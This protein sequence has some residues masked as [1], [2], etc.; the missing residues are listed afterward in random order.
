MKV[1]VITEDPTHDQHIVK[2][3]V[4]RIFRDRGR[5]PRL[6]FA[7]K[8]GCRGWQQVLA[9]EAIA[10]FISRFRDAEF[11]I[12]I[13]DRDCDC[14]RETGIVAQRLR[15]A[16]AAGR[17]IVACIAVEELE[18]WALALH[19][20]RS[21]EWTVDWSVVRAECDSKRVFFERFV[22]RRNWHLGVG[23]GRKAAMANLPDRW[24]QLKSR[25]TEIDRLAVE[26]TPRTED[27]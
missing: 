22:R 23:K 24:S 19:H 12:L 9:R 16:R 21:D 4:E 18:T 3:V 6:Y 13:V 17:P 10:W 25:C 7:S 11:L 26:L 1:V 15:E 2:P 8:P 20:E 14:N 5:N 27:A